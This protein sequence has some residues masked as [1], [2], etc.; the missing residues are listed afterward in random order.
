MNDR[1]EYS[2]EELGAMSVARN[3]HQ[4]WIELLRDRLAG[5]WAVALPASIVV[6]CIASL[7]CW[8]VVP[9]SYE[10]SGLIEVDA[11]R[12]VVVSRLPEE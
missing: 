10:S 11:R 1:R 5:R 9:A 2:N 7:A 6:G 8:Y 12:G 3:E 4:N